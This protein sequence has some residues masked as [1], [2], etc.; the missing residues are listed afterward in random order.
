MAE[1]ISGFGSGER[2]DMTPGLERRMIAIDEWFEARQSKPLPLEFYLVA[3]AGEVGEA[4]NLYKKRMR[5]DWR[6]ADSKFWEEFA[7]ELAD[8]QIYLSHLARK[9]GINLDA[10]VEQKIK[11]CEERWGI[12]PKAP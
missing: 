10:A 12:T 9:A 1:G 3:L 8:V 7:L 5:G 11:I 2:D 6:F 4:C